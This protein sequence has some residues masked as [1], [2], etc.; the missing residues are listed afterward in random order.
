MLANLENYVQNLIQNIGKSR[1]FKAHRG[2]PAGHCVGALMR[3]SIISTLAGLMLVAVTVPI[4]HAADDGDAPQL[5]DNPPERYIV[6][7]GDTLWGISKRFLKDPWR[8]PDIWGMNKDEVRN[9]HLIYPGNVIV[10]DRSG[11]SP[12]LRLEEEGVGGLAEASR[13]TGVG[14]TVKLKPRVRVEQLTAAAISSIPASI[15]DPFLTRPLIVGEEQFEL[16]PSVVATPESRVLTGPGDTVYV[17]GLPPNAP[18]VWQVFRPSKALFDPVS[19]E[20]LGY[21]VIY[22]GEV[23][24][25]Q[26]GEV[27]AVRITRA[28]QEIGVGDRLIESPPSD[29][30]AYAPR[31]ADR[32]LQGMIISAPETTVSEIGQYQVVVINLGARNGVEPGQVFALYRASRL[33][34]PRRLPSST[35]NDPDRREI[36]SI[37]SEFTDKKNT[38]PVLVPEERYGLIFTFRVFEKVSYA[39]VMNMTR[40]A[41]VLDLVRAP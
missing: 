33:V 17:R 9:P 29:I 37:H 38:E 11:A 7:K 8:W 34:E 35:S 14:S 13:G 24:L 25:E 1:N 15:I 30:L 32:T 20:K 16:A 6:V 4:L 19:G 28:R 22:L 2:N 31:S 10:L 21:E 27:S 23:Q 41:N 40:S 18:P 3:N 5:Q 26:A 36:R 39:L 12:R